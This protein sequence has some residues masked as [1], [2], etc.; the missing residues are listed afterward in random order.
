MFIRL[1]AAQFL[2]C[3]IY[4]FTFAVGLRNAIFAV[5]LYQEYDSLIHF[6]RDIDFWWVPVQTD[7]FHF[8]VM[9]LIIAA[10]LG[11]GRWLVK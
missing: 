3:I 5:T 1:L 2:T 11:L 7:L 9:T 4:L 8:A 6:W 10:L